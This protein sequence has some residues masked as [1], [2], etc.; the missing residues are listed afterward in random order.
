M[1]PTPRLLALA[2]LVLFAAPLRAND[3]EAAIGLGGIELKANSAITMDEEDLFL[4]K[5]EVRVRYRY[6]NRTDR[7]VEVLVSFP[8]PPVRAADEALYADQALPDYSHLDFRTTVDGKPVKLDTVK[9]AE[10]GGRDVTARLTALGWPV[11]WIDGMGGEPDFVKA[12]PPDRRAALIREGLLRQMAG[13]DRRVLPAW[14]AVTHI[15]RRQVFPAHRTVEVTHRYVPMVG[16]SVGGMLEPAMRKAYP[17]HA[18]Q[19][20]V[21]KAFFAAF[22]RKR[23]AKRKPGEEFVSYGEVWISYVLSSGR[24]WKGPIGRFRLVVD[25][26]RPENLVSFCMSGVKKISPTQFEVRRTNFEPKG[27]LDVLIADWAQQE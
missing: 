8:L 9:R 27:D 17:E 2:V 4:S 13:D 15:T 25:K 3:S 1:T 23:A 7:D 24:N 22:D 11:D 19:Y 12:L 10:I 26:G 5:E 20:C 14:D 6:T 16:G 21:D 18:R